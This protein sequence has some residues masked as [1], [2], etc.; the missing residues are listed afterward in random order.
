MV[1]QD[2]HCLSRNSFS[3]RSGVPGTTWALSPAV[4]FAD[5]VMYAMMST[6]SLPLK[7]RALDALR[8]HRVGHA[9]SVA[10]HPAATS[11]GEFMRLSE[12]SAGPTLPP[13]PPTAWH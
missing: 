7:A 9:G 2:A 3:P 13:L 1:W 5:V 4:S 11:T 10:P 6:S 8:F 12:S